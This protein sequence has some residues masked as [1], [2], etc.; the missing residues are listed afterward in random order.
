MYVTV[1]TVVFSYINFRPKFH[2]L[3]LLEGFARVAVSRPDCGLVLCGVGGYAEPDLQQAIAARLAQSDLAGRVHV[4]EDL[5][6]NGFLTALTRSALFL[7]SHVSDGVCSSVLEALSLRVPVVAAENGQRPAG[8]LTY[9]ATD[10]ADLAAVL[11]DA[12]RRRHEIAKTLPVPEIPDTLSVEA[13]VLTGAEGPA[14]KAD[15]CAA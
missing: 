2:P 10:P 11:T 14:R 15:P 4:I 9:D 7:R 3:E 12:L 6:H 1:P 8:V 5:E 13:D